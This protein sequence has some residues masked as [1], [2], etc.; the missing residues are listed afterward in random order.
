M[1]R[2]QHPPDDEAGDG[3]HDDGSHGDGSHGDGSH[4][5]GSHGDAH[6]RVKDADLAENYDFIYKTIEVLPESQVESW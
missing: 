6:R 1:V 3:S 5:D 2:R 4:G